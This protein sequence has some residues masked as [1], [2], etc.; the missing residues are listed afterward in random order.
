M[1]KIVLLLF[2]ALL[3]GIGLYAQETKREADKQFMQINTVESVVAGGLGRSK[4]IVTNPD[5]SQKESDLENLFS[6]TGIN[7]KNIK[8]NEDKLVRT[9][10]QFTDDGWKLDHVTSLTLS[11][12][13]S[14]A[15][16]IFMTRYLLS[17]PL[18][19]KA[20]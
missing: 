4:M 20:F 15:G 16:G 8:D 9:L 3:T 7:F 5:G 19:K 2:I 17:K 13:D 14:G 10:K 12:N 6:M 11:Q 1:K 18:E